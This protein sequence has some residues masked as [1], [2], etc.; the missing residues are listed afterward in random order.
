MLF[1]LPFNSGAQSQFHRWAKTP[2]PVYQ[3][4]S[5]TYGLISLLA[6]IYFIE[7]RFSVADAFQIKPSSSTLIALGALNKTVIANTG[8][9]YRMLTAPLLNGSLLGLSF[10]II[11]LL[12]IGPDLE[13]LIGRLWFTA[14]FS[15]SAII[16]SLISFLMN[17]AYTTSVGT[18]GVM[19]GLFIAL[20]IASYRLAKEDRN[21]IQVKTL[22]IAF[23]FL[24]PMVAAAALN[25]T[26]IINY[27]AHIGG[28]L[29]GAMIGLVL[30]KRWPRNSRVAP[31][32]E[33]MGPMLGLILVFFAFSIISVSAHYATYKKMIGL[34]PTEEIP[35]M[36][37]D[38]LSQSSSLIARY[39][40]DPRPHVFRALQLLDAGDIGG[41]IS[42]LKAAID[43]AQSMNFLFGSEYQTIV[44]EL[45]FELR[46]SFRNKIADAQQIAQ[47]ICQNMDVSQG[48]T[49]RIMKKA[50]LCE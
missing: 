23:L 1:H 45:L 16:G 7:L 21:R 15:L 34:M 14:L 27:G 32:C 40:T 39:P 20:Y 43:D 29:T 49:Q 30:L 25:N 42:E 9:W 18:A 22:F 24:W 36:A 8:E 10:N 46:T 28:A 19:T 4:P 12:L 5:L 33:Y 26:N 50:G 2:V 37:A 11:V 38:K 31:F 41:E 6:I 44:A 35:S 48:E 13:K 17:P 3:S 47:P